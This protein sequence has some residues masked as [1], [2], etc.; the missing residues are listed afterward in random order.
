MLVTSSCAVPVH[1]LS[2]V[3]K[4]IFIGIGQNDAEVVEG[5]ICFTHCDTALK[6]GIKGA[7]AS[8][9]FAVAHL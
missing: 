2:G 3:Q 1:C 8:H 7:Q 6:Q 5:R 9:S 4:I